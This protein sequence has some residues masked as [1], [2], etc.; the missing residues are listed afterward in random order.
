M[1]K[2]EKRVVM[3]KMIRLGAGRKVMEK[4]NDWQY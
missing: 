1:F 4:Q 3:V 2:Q